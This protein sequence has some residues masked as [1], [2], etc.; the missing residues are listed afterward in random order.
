M[1]PELCSPP[2]RH[3]DGF[4][5]ISPLIVSLLLVLAGLAIRFLVL[6]ADRSRAAGPV[7]ILVAPQIPVVAT[8]IGTV[9]ALLGQARRAI[10]QQH[11]LAP[12][13]ANAFEWYLA[14]L[15]RQPGNRVAAEALRETFPF[16]AAAAEQTVER[17]EPAEARRQIDLLARADPGNYTL[18]LLRA[19][20]AARQ[21]AVAPSPAP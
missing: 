17:G 11:L 6:P 9:D 18:T 12:A 14:V 8:D 21:Q 2:P 7:A 4:T 13:G 1:S 10:G 20:L 19:R 5:R 16:A 15:R 3:S